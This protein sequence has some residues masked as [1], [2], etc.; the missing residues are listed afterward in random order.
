[1]PGAAP[2]PLT[3]PRPDNTFRDLMQWRI[4][5]VLIVSSQYDYFIMEEDGGLV[6]QISSAYLDLHLSRAPRLHRAASAAEALEILEGRRFDLVVT[7]RQ[8]G[9]MDALAFGREIK[10]R[11]PALP[12]VLLLHRMSD[13]PAVSA[14]EAESGIDRV[15]VWSGDSSVFLAIIKSVEDMMNVD[16]DIATANVRVILL[17]EDAPRYYSSFLPVLYAE[18]MRYCQA[19]LPEDINTMHRLYRMRA[20]PKILLARSYE[21]ARALY[22]RYRRNL[23]A[24]ISDIEVPRGGKLS[25]QAGIEFS[26]ECRR[27]NPN[28][29][30]LFLSASEE[31]RDFVRELD[32]A[33]LSKT[34]PALS[35]ELRD[36]IAGSLGF[37]DFVFRTPGG[38]EV[39]RA[40]TLM[41]MEA[42]LPKVPDDSLRHH[43]EHRHFGNWFMARGEFSLAEVLERRL[44]GGLG[45]L[46]EAREFLLEA[47]VR[48]SVDR[49]KG[50][51]SDFS[52]QGLGSESFLMRLGRGSLGGK[53]RGLAF[54]AH[55]MSRVDFEKEFP[56]VAVL[57]PRTV[58]V[59]VGEFDRFIEENNLRR[60][61][62]QERPDEEVAAA[63]LA[64]K[65]PAELTEGLE[66]LLDRVRY[67]LAVRSS[68][69]LEDSHNVPFAGIYATYMLPNCHQSLD[70][71]REQLHRAVKLV[72]ASVFYGGARRY[73]QSVN[74]RL[75]EE[76]MGI[77]VQEI[78]GRHHGPRF[79]PDVCGVAHSYN[80][81]PTGYL[82]PEDG[83]AHVALGLGRVVTDDGEALRFSPA[84]PGI[85][86]QFTTVR[87]YLDLSQKHFYALDIGRPEALPVIDDAADLMRCSLAEAEADGAL[88][89]VGAVYSAEDDAIRD[90]VYGKGPRVVNFGNILKHNSF[91]LA[92]LLSRFLAMGQAGMGV[93]VDIEF[94][95][96]LPP[97][98]EAGTPE[99]H[100]L[101]IR[102]MFATGDESA[103]SLDGIAQADVLCRSKNTMS[104]G[105]FTGIRDIVYAVPERFDQ[106]RTRE[107]A[108]EFGRIN[109]RLL[110][111]KQPYLAIGMG[112]W[113]TAEAS[114]GIPVQ[115]SQICGAKAL[116]ETGTADYVVDPSHGT[117]FFQN[118]TAM[119]VAYLNVQPQ[120]DPLDWAWLAAQETVEELKY[121]RHVR[122]ER[123]LRILIDGRKRQGAVLK[124]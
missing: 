72:Y 19:L 54:L 53:A 34:S 5:E 8:I 99:F 108:E 122:A 113:G 37:G 117:H 96:K 123:P 83:V 61:S 47:I 95:A 107:I 112:R 1:V 27:D 40:A 26:R 14:P 97:P 87:D 13:V 86:P 7:M 69:L 22:G 116:I 105:E 64:G 73:L 29:P 60:F 16:P 50:R 23:L 9:D 33:F 12:V 115:W 57:I 35:Y 43:L 65:L 93:P 49:R 102:P 120:S 38:Q 119:R 81:Y 98:G 41:Q 78:V 46:A 77:V 84:H 51:I 39:A 52:P 106:L 74:V 75:A 85:L 124:K 109:A 79:Y 94:A 36:F 111:E 101:Q 18:I 90:G 82:R 10:R 80:F 11:H 66:V 28:M 55:L 103:V 4:T 110:A 31:K 91:P 68:S 25:P 20:R 62:A 6:E 70:V 44:A 3:E 92:R 58:A 24:V 100:M 114:L 118:M 42:T 67:P 104:N 59:S 71:R 15:F 45:E 30:L 48:N 56:G 88:H 17:L 21:E 63:F 76:K 32:A 89:H 121:V 2:Q